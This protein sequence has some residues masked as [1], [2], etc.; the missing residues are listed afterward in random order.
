MLNVVSLREQVYHFLRQEMMAGRLP[1]GA[2]IN[3]TELSQLLGIS[4]TPMRDALIR[5]ETEGFVT[6]LPRRGV[7]VAPLTLEDVH[8]AYDII[9]ALEARV[10]RDV[11][12]KIEE[13]HF[14]ELEALN[15]TMRDDLAAGNY[16][17]YY[18]GNLAFHDVYLKLSRNQEISRLIMPMKQRLYDFPR[19][20]YLVEWE[21]SNCEEHDR[22][23]GQLR[24]GDPESASRFLRDVHWSY[25]YQ[26]RYIV[27]FYQ[28]RQN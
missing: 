14:A 28:G 16:E 15:Q 4:K 5:L 18:Q 22:F 27:Q 6:I 1:P 21:R 17:A 23:I 3:P 26:E 9:G 25:T 10:V 13:S 19:R 2:T 12:P 7:R 8:N 11:F 20:T 24:S